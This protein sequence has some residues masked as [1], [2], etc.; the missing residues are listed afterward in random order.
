LT[1]LPGFRQ[2]GVPIA[3][4]ERLQGRTNYN[5]RRSLLV[6]LDGVLSFSTLPLRI[7]TFLGFLMT[8]VSVTVAAVYILW[9]LFDPS[10]FGPGWP[11]IFVSIFL[12]GGLQLIVLGILGEYL[13]RIFIEVQNRPVYWV[14]YE[15]GFPEK[16]QN[17]EARLLEIASP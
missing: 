7:A 9:R 10:I 3:R 5:F 4:A 11:S 8:F 12:L 15:V 1:V 17:R 14:D 16:E 13:A 6:A 2:I